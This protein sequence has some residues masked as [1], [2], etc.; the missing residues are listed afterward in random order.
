MTPE[1]LKE[2]N[3]YLNHTTMKFPDWYKKNRETIIGVANLLFF[4]KK[5]KAVLLSLIAAFDAV[6]LGGQQFAGV[7]PRGGDVKLSDIVVN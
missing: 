6:L 3:H 5:G 2:I 4:W 7:Q 1:H